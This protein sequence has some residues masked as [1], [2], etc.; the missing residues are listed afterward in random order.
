MYCHTMQHG[1][2]SI[3]GIRNHYTLTTM[4]KHTTTLKRFQAYHLDYLLNYQ[5][6][7]SYAVAKGL[8]Y[9]TAKHRLQTAAKV[10]DLVIS[11][12]HTS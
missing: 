3:R 2:Y 4:D 6:V 1:C 7:G 5:S 12:N 8:T 10:H 11:S 9:E